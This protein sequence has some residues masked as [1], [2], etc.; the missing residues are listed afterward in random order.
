MSSDL[1]IDPY[2]ALEPSLTA[3]L[4]GELTEAQA[5]L[6]RHA[7]ESDPAVARKF[8]QL[9]YTISLVR[10]VE[11]PAA[12]SIVAESSEPARLSEER[13]QQLLQAFKTVRPERFKPAAG[14]ESRWLVPA[15]AACAL[16]ST[17]VALLILGSP[18][19]IR[20]MAKLPSTPTDMEIRRKLARGDSAPRPERPNVTAQMTGMNIWLHLSPVLSNYPSANLRRLRTVP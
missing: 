20:R 12:V 10:E 8:E 16:I 17:V 15:A 9:K 11:A 19:S 6:V 18:R 2:E 1:P 7:I 3:L 13:R 4:L 14:R 5:E